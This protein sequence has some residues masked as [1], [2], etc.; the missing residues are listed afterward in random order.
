MKPASACLPDE[1][2]RQRLGRAIDRRRAELGIPVVR[3]AS[4][5][6]VDLSQLVK[7]LRGR[8]GISP[9]AAA[10]VARALGWTLGELYL[11]AFPPRRSRVRPSDSLP[12]P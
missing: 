5:S 3:L 7:V 8:T 4:Q 9:Y 10:H 6:G 12:K 11:A 2:I 1:T